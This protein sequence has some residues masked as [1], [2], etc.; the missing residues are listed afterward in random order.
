MPLAPFLRNSLNQ[1]NLDVE[2]P[3]PQGGP[4]SFPTYNHN[5]KYSPSNTYLD[6]YQEAASPNSSFGINNTTINNNN[7]FKDGTSL[8]VENDDPNGG[9]NRT[10][11][12]NIPSGIYS[13]PVVNNTT[14][15][16]PIGGILMNGDGTVYKT[17]LHQ[18]LNKPGQ[19]YEEQNH[20]PIPI[21]IKKPGFLS[22]LN[23]SDID[24]PNIDLGGA[25]SGISTG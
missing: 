13:T 3:Q 12:T 1:T 11:S 6:N 21:P 4:N 19:K 20:D 15:A 7:I 9:P 10:N 18:Y 14:A 25:F 23:L 8:D 16:T 2:N 5:Q 22:N 24:L 17:L